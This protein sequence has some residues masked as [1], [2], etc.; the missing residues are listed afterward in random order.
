M[1]DHIG[2]ISFDWREDKKFV[3]PAEAGIQGVFW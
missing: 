2:R 1:R 3:M